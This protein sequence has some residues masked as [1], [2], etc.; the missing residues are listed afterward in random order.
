M[1]TG[2]SNAELAILLVDAQKGILEQTLR[3]Y[4]IVTLMGIRNLVLAVNKMDLVKYDKN[5]FQ[6][7]DT[8]F[9]TLILDKDLKQVQVIPISAVQGLNITKNNQKISLFFI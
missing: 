5:V 7:I 9:R 8:D 2:A 1:A 3:H 4:R 6:K